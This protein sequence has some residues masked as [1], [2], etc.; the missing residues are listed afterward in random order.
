[1]SASLWEVQ[2]TIYSRLASASPEVASG[3]VHNEYPKAGSTTF[4]YVLF[5]A[6]Q[7][8]P[9]DVSTTDGNGDAGVSTW[10]DLHVFDQVSSGVRGDRQVRQTFDRMH[11]LLHG[12]SLSVVGRGSALSWVRTIRIFTEP[13]GVTRHGVMTVEVTHRD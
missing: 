5:H 13:D 8:I 2:K 7:D 10:F 3:G 6:S 4:P 1:M 11:A 12:A 9:D